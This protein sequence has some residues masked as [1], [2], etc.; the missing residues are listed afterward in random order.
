[1]PRQASEEGAGE[2]ALPAALERGLTDFLEALRVEAGAARNTLLAY[3]RDLEAFLDWCAEHE[4]IARWQDI[5]PETIVSHLNACRDAGAAEAS[6]ARR[7]SALRM[8]LR[9]QVLEGRLERDPAALLSA[10]VLRRALPSVLSVEEV[11]RLLAAPGTDGWRA[12]RDSALLEV[13]YACG[14]RISEALSVRVDALEPSLRVLVLHGKGD[15]ARVVPIGARA[16]AAVERW[17]DEGRAT[18]PDARRRRELFL[19][20]SGRPRERSS[21]W[22]LVP[23][24]AQQAGLRDV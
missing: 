10:P 20:R 19:S 7:L 11:E 18:L 9:H 5:R 16:R 1:M 17:R 14:A 22:R 13:L 6:V 15:K 4:R 21:G 8:C 23:R 12:Q 2:R 3:R 24:A